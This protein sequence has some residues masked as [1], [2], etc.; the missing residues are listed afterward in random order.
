[1]DFV[2]LG[3]PVLIL[4]IQV[5]RFDPA[6][7]T[8][9]SLS[10]NEMIHARIHFLAC[11][12][13]GDVHP[14]PLCFSS[15]TD[16]MPSTTD[17]ALSVSPDGIWSEPHVRENNKCFILTF[18]SP[19]LKYP[20]TLFWSLQILAATASSAANDQ[21][22]AAAPAARPPPRLWGGRREP[23][24]G[25]TAPVTRQKASGDWMRVD[26]GGNK[27]SVV[28]PAPGQRKTLLSLGRPEPR[29]YK[30]RHLLVDRNPQL[31]P[32]IICLRS[33]GWKIS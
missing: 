22:D 12:S 30:V 31:H 21:P 15:S 28:L 19:K 16:S 8:T 6:I 10:L 27:R 20:L 26:G 3:V 23:S 1:V 29:K 18:H 33:L 24:E 11:V 25:A 5:S 32:E 7:E 13:G 4:E 17:I 9:L 14:G 2:A